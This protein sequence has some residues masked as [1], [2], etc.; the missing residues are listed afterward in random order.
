MKRIVYLFIG[1]AAIY[2]TATFCANQSFDNPLILY[3]DTHYEASNIRYTI[4]ILDFIVGGNSAAYSIVS[5]REYGGERTHYKVF[6]AE[7]NKSSSFE[8]SEISGMR[9]VNL[10]IIGFD[11]LGV[12]NIP[13]IVGNSDK[14]LYR[15]KLSSKKLEYIDSSGAYEKVRISNAMYVNNTFFIQDNLG[16]VSLVENDKTINVIENIKIESIKDVKRQD[17]DVYFL[18]SV[19]DEGKLD[20]N[21][22]HL[23]MKDYEEQNFVKLNIDEKDVT[24]NFDIAFLS[25]SK[26][27]ISKNPRTSPTVHPSA[28]LIQIKLRTNDIDY[29]FAEETATSVIDMSIFCSGEALNPIT[30]YALNNGEEDDLIVKIYGEKMFIAPIKNR[31]FTAIRTRYVDGIV[32]VLSAYRY[33]VGRDIY[34][35]LSLS[36]F[37][38]DKSLPCIPWEVE[39][40]ESIIQ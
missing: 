31:L 19:R 35:E 15:Y 26:L 28:S 40:T 14:K 11:D 24:S 4:D 13:F 21:L 30:A 27:F 23:N 7:Y 16:G 39:N 1:L 32:S 10:G 34:S 37:E 29:K 18:A 20:I 2:S 8:F 6:I 12:L 22:I 3:S 9:D 36:Q 38:L 33:L 5:L 17:D 25:K